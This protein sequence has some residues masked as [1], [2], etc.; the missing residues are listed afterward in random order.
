MQR[1]RKRN[2]LI[3]SIIALLMFVPSIALAADCTSPTIG[4]GG[5]SWAPAG[6]YGLGCGSD[7]CWAT[8][9]IGLRFQV[10]KVT[11]KNKMELIGNGV[12]VWSNDTFFNGYFSNPNKKNL[13]YK[14]NCTGYLS[15]ADFFNKNFSKYFTISDARTYVANYQVKQDATIFP[16]FNGGSLNS[17]ALTYAN[18]NPTGGWLAN[19]L[20]Y[21]LQKLNAGNNKKEI[22]SLFGF[23]DKQIADMQTSVDDYYITAE[24]L[25][26]THAFAAHGRD[27]YI[28][29]TASEM[30]HFFGTSNIYNALAIERDVAK[31]DANL[32]VKGNNGGYIKKVGKLGNQ[33]FYT[34]FDA[35]AC[36]YGYGYA[37]W[38]L[39]VIC[40]DCSESCDVACRDQGT[41]KGSAARMACAIPWCS[42]NVKDNV[43]QCIK[44]CTEVKDDEGCDKDNAKTCEEYK[45]NENKITKT[46]TCTTTSGKDDVGGSI[47]A[48][49]KICYD[50]KNKLTGDK[51]EGSSYKVSGRAYSKKIYY[52][53]VCEEDMDLKELPNIQTLYLSESNTAKLSYAYRVE[54]K[55]K[56][57]LYWKTKDK[58]WVAST[59]YNAVKDKTL[60]YKELEEIKKAK[61]N[62]V[63]ECKRYTDEEDKKVRMA[64]ADL[65]ANCNPKP[66]DCRNPKGTYNIVS[67]DLKK[68]I[69]SAET[70]FNNLVVYS[71]SKTAEPESLDTTLKFKT[72]DY[73]SKETEKTEELQM[74]PVICTSKIETAGD[75]KKEILCMVNGKEVDGTKTITIEGTTY[76][77]QGTGGSTTEVG[78][79]TKVYKETVIYAM[80]S[81]Y[82]EAQTEQAGK[83]TH[84]EKDCNKSG[85]GLCREYQYEYLFDLYNG[86]DIEKYAEYVN[87]K[88]NKIELNIKGGLCDEFNLTE[89]CDYR[90]E[91]SYCEACKEYTEGTEAYNKCYEEKCSCEAKCAGNR[92]CKNLYCPEYCETAGCNWLIEINECTGCSACDSYTPGSNDYWL[93]YFDS[94]CSQ[95]A[96]NDCWALKKCC[97]GKCDKLYTSDSDKEQCYRSCKAE[98]DICANPKADSVYRSVTLGDPFPDRSEKNDSIGLNW[99]Y[100]TGY[101]TEAT[102]T[103]SGYY[104]ETNG[105]DN[106]YE[107]MVTIKS[108]DLEK[109]KD[110]VNDKNYKTYMKTSNYT[111]TVDSRAYCSQFIYE[112][113]SNYV[114]LGSSGSV[115]C[116]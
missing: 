19:N 72:Y 86:K 15:D 13:Y 37:V 85:K 8:H 16:N 18:N 70:R 115:G 31:Y 62:A 103:K 21:K 24:M 101:I 79:G 20:L 14:A 76:V 12:D 95:Q 111:S 1:K 52:K 63:A 84:S 55:N 45:K 28:Y 90:F 9:N 113:I 49:A 91:T 17:W 2:S 114:T 33:E 3:L 97:Y 53:V 26:A 69:T 75:N 57:T 27:L 107:Y 102:D 73:D 43:G 83:I 112:T 48:K 38:N 78:A 35:A 23:T 36:E 88:L 34:Q 80:P 106:N 60:L 11:A 50:E 82:V 61:N 66:V 7:K 46:H 67:C 81:S 104:D 77:C 68:T 108:N 56:C 71:E 10:Y 116:K 30:G 58:K 42:S 94:C 5:S 109:L 98:Y 44:E 100:K 110:T 74:F 93:C 92:L 39:G 51:T 87:S 25:M 54:Y 65:D 99:K 105:T 41:E 4:G 22:K 40:E 47:S 29:G 64:Q 59:T 6:E 32:V 96:N 89:N